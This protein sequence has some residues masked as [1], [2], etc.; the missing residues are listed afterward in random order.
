MR[1]ISVMRSFCFKI[2]S[3]SFLITF[4]SQGVATSIDMYVPFFIITDYDVRLI[5]RDSSVG[6]HLLV[7]FTTSFHRF[8][9]MLLI[10][11][12]V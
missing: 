1:W 9:Y 4:M 2:F 5:V 12:I 11:F 3:A 10:A 6:S 8:W 7:T